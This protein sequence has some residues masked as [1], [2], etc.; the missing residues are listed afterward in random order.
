MKSVRFE[1]IGR[2]CFDSTK[3]IKFQQHQ[4]ELWPGFDI[5]LCQKE[6]GVYL[7]IEPCHKVIRYESALDYIISIRDM[8]D[9]KGLDF[10]REI[11][12]EL[13]NVT[14]ITRYNNKPYQVTGITFEK[15]PN[16]KFEHESSQVSFIDYYRRK[17]NEDIKDEN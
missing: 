1:Q 15:T 9:S 16:S 14:V 12:K 10:M 11:K 7:N 6:G 3:A 17:Y 5:R 8:C 2:N 13:E 4:I